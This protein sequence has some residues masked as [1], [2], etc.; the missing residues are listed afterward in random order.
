MRLSRSRSTVSAITGVVAEA[1]EDRKRL[2]V[3]RQAGLRLVEVGVTS[4]HAVEAPRHE[5]LRRRATGLTS[6]AWR[7]N[8]PARWRSLAPPTACLTRTALPIP[9]DRFGRSARARVSAAVEVVV[10]PLEL[11]ERLGRAPAREVQLD[12]RL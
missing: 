4:S 5:R 8:S 10:R 7:R 11:A 9:R 6:S 12:G 2:L 1:L 3:M